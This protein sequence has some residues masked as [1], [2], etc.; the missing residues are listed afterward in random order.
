MANAWDKVALPYLKEITAGTNTDF[1][2]ERQ[3]NSLAILS[4][5]HAT[6]NV[7]D[8][9]CGDGRFTRDL[10]TRFNHVYGVDISSILLKKAKKLCKSVKFF[11]CDLEKDF[12]K[13]VTKFDTV[14]C[15]L[16]LM[17]IKDLDNI[18]SNSFNWLTDG[19]TLIISITHPIK[20]ITQANYKGYLLETQISHPV[21]G[22]KHTEIEFVSR[23]IETYINSFTKHG[24]VLETISEIGVPDSFVIK[25]PQYRPYQYKPYR[26][27]LKFIK[28]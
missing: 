11:Y 26:L 4:W 20:W 21:A 8:L 16:L 23:T 1:A 19:V 5:C 6:E 24:F 27:N 17:Y 12:P 28:R 7:L 10:E 3:V 14:I 15:K 13:F 22:I 9:G 25:Y 2:Y 18:A